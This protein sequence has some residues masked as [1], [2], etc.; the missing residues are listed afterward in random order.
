MSGWRQTLYDTRYRKIL[1]CSTNGI[2]YVNPQGPN[3]NPDPALSAQDVRETFKRM[4][5]NDEETV[6][7]TAGGHTF[8]KAHGAGDEVL[9]EAEPEGAPM[10]LMG[11]AGK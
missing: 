10:E 7:L 8:G 5:M 6:A 3:G 11:Q 1:S 9:V 2:N 4:A